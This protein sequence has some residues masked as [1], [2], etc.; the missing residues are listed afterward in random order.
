MII[1]LYGADDY[2]RSERK[3][4]YIEEY[5][6]K[7]SG[8]GMGIF[9][10]LE[11]GRFEKFQEFVKNRSI[12]DSFKMVI[13]E[14]FFEE[15]SKDSI[16]AIKSLVQSGRETTILIS[17]GKAP[18]K[19]FHFLLKE[20]VRAE[21]FSPLEGTK[22][23]G[24]IRDEAKR[25]ELLLSAPAMRFLAEAYQGNSW[26][27]VT[28]LEKLS[29][30]GGRA[31]IDTEDLERFGIELAPNFW[32]LMNDLKNSDWKRRLGSLER[33]FAEQESSVKVFNMLSAQWQEKLG[34]MAAYDVAVKSGKLEYE[35]VL[36]DLAL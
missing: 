16:A 12:F 11:E 31:P 1:F 24:F 19:E 2:R 15:A 6:K 35:E 32:S 10:L 18:A 8:L 29:F 27:L 14:H 30:L 13:L 21:E 9:D 26:R 22:W 7:H 5:K 20:P 33:M 3:K 28:E 17:E 23:S 25:R 34:E 36:L 4:F